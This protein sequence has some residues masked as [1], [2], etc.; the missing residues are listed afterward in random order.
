MISRLFHR[1]HRL[2]KMHIFS[3]VK[4]KNPRQNTVC[5]GRIHKLS[6]VPPCFV[7][8]PTPSGM[9]LHSERLTRVLRCRIRGAHALSSAPSAGHLKD[10]GQPDSQQRGLSVWAHPPLFPLQRF[11][12]L[13]H[14]ARTLSILFSTFRHNCRFA[15]Y[16]YKKRKREIP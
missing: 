11:T 13:Y 12:A 15:A 1:R 6:A 8:N 7:G 16:R 14:R 3:S 2:D 4:T 5:Q 9:P 10:S